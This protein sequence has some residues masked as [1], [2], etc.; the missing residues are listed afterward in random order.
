[1]QISGG[2]TIIGGNIA[3]PG[4]IVMFIPA[5]NVIAGSAPVNSSIPTISGYAANSNPTANTTLVAN[6]GTWTNTPTSYTYQWVRVQ[7]PANVLGTSSTYFIGPLAA[8]PVSN[9]TITF[10]VAV[11]AINAYGSASA[12]SSATSAAI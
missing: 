4:G 10:R 5:G 3:E 1:M 2:F 11:T 8:Y 9:N 7:S 12:N 6:V